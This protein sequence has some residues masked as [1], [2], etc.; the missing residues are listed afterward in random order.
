MSMSMNSES[1]DSIRPPRRPAAAAAGS[2]VE[3][4]FTVLISSLVPLVGALFVPP[5]WQFA[6]DVLGGTLCVVG[7]VLLVRH[8]MALRQQQN[9]TDL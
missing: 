7:L 4:W 3:P 2:A 1:G 5:P 8:E 6:L 9:V